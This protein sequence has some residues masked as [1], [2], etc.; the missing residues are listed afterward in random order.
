[1]ELSGKRAIV[2]GGGRGLGRAIVEQ[3]LTKGVTV[4][5]VE[6]DFDGLDDLRP[7]RDGLTL[8]ECDVSDAEQVAATLE[9]YHGEFGAADILINNA[10]ILH[11]A[12]LV[13]ITP[14]G[15]E[16][17]DLDDW[18][19]V[20]AT[21]LNSVFY[22]SAWVA[23]GMIARRARGVIVNISS[24]AAAGNAGQSAYSAAKA[25]V[26]ALTAVWAKELGPHGIR[27]VAIAPGFIDTE[28]TAASMAE[29]TLKRTI[30]KVPLG[31]L[32]RPEEVAAAVLCVVENDYVSGAV[33]AVDGGLVI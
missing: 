18:R 21:D 10:G 28:S 22:M 3:L 11:S 31:R 16:R 23:E 32:G 8:L 30:R 5:V 25:G 9:R 26:N 14:S 2:T 4:S 20:L 24:T 33:V 1:V 6:L 19:R 29:A 12:P 7:N 27:V 15:T 17:H 13:K